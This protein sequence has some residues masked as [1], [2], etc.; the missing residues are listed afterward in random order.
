MIISTQLQCLPRFSVVMFFLSSLTDNNPDKVY[1]EWYSVLMASWI[2]FGLAW[3]SL[4]INH[5]I[6]LLE[7]IN[8][9]LKHQW[10]GRRKEEGSE[11]QCKN[12]DIQVD[13]DKETPR[14]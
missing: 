12:Q 6:D 4:L 2:F 5:S 7:Q 9:Y 10:S 1:P 13:K 14:P 3:L 8:A 11:T